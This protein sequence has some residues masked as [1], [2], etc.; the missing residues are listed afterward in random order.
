MKMNRLENVW[1]TNGTNPN[2]NSIQF[3]WQQIFFLKIRKKKKPQFYLISKVLTYP[4]PQQIMNLQP[5]GFF[6]IF[7]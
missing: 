2:I 5:C 3:H 6:F 4:P 1:K 7:F